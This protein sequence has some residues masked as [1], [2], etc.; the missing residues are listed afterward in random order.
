MARRDFEA[1]KKSLLAAIDADPKYVSPYD[2]LGV[3]AVQQGNWKEAADWSKHAVSLNPVEFPVSWF[4]NG[5]AN[6]NLKDLKAAQASS[7]QALKADVNHKLPQIENLLAQIYYEQG[8]YEIAANHL[9]EYLKLEPNAKNADA[10]KQ[11]LLK[12]EQASA[13][14][15]K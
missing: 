1:A 3:M 5:V 10:L 2:R 9:R 7:E 13:K 8:N 15:N 6:Y 12:L 11:E 14:P 4:V